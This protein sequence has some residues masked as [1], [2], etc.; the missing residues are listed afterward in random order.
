M[1]KPEAAPVVE[2]RPPDPPPPDWPANAKP[3]APRV[4]WDGRDLSISAANSSLKQ[5]LQD[6]STATGV[7]VEGMG[8]DQRSDTRIYGSYGP[9]A[10]R[11]VL[12]KLLEGSGYNVMMVGD[13]GE[14]TPREL[15]LTAKTGHS[16]S[17]QSQTGAG[18]QNQVQDEDQQE[19]P[20][21]PELPPIQQRP[22]GNP[23]APGQGLTPQQLLQ[24]MQQRQQQLQQQQQQ[25]PPGGQP[26]ND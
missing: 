5:I 23:Q 7:K 15:V 14:G 8:N 19:E 9:A 25:Q 24:E 21:Q 17:P 22:F 20:E 2:T 18:A 16:G 12:G 3:V 6:V 13:Q 10:P 11:D 26:P 4:G 1:V